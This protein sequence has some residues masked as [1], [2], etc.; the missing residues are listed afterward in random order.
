MYTFIGDP[1]LYFFSDAVSFYW[2]SLSFVSEV[3]SFYWG[4]SSLFRFRGGVVLLGVFSLILWL[5]CIIEDP[6]LYFVSEVVWL[7][8]FTLL[9]PHN[10]PSQTSKFKTQTSTQH[11]STVVFTSAIPW[12]SQH[13]IKYKNLKKNIKKHQLHRCKYVKF[14]LCTFVS[15]SLKELW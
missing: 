2:G 7:W 3:V 9:L 1:C 8:S 4:P 15:P 6:C 13:Q 11:I 14:F 5:S 10:S 12:K